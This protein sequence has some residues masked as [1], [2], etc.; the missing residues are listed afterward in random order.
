MKAIQNQIAE[1]AKVQKLQVKWSTT[2]GQNYMKVNIFFSNFLY[3][4]YV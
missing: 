3:L 4:R 1:V 2:K